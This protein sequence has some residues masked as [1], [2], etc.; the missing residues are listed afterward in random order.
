MRKVYTA[1][2]PVTARM[3]QDLLSASGYKAIIQGEL[4]GSGAGE[5]PADAYPTVW[6]VD[7]EDEEPA[8]KLIQQW[9]QRESSL[10]LYESPWTCPNCGESH[11][12]QFTQCWKCGEQR[13]G[14]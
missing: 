13:L 1:P 2:D 10:Q 5:L 7:N 9:E 6:V 3:A 11:A 8:T 14:G 12:A 4:L